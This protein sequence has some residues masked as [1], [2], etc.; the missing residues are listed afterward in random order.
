M[1]GSSIA[2]PASRAP[3]SNAVGAQDRPVLWITWER[4]R[5][6]L[7]LAR[8]LNADLLV[9]RGPRA[10]PARYLY[11]CYRTV[12]ELRRRRPRIVVGQNP[13]LILAATLCLLRP[14]LRFS[15]VIDRHSNF[16]LDKSGGLKWRMFHLLSRYTVR[17]A[18]L[19]IVTNEPLRRVVE[20]W[21]GRGFVLPDR[22]PTIEAPG[23]SRART[24]TIELVFICS[25]A[26]DEPLD[27]LRRAAA[28]LA[29]TWTLFVTG[30][31]RRYLR[32]NAEKRWPPNVRFTG[33]LDERDYWSLL[34]SCDA[35]IVLTTQ[36]HT[37]TCGAYEAVALGKPA[38]LSDTAT[39]R[40]YF[41]S[42]AVYASPNEASIAAGIS[43]AIRRRGEL[44]REMQVLRE[45]LSAS[46][47]TT[48]QDLRRHLDALVS[49]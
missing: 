3:A 2:A 31:G 7:E 13:S 28:T 44:A 41:A 15:L 10:R 25:F 40:E 32:G 16:E 47:Q 22:L 43:E 1:R 12:R 34:Q 30:D 20:S 14:L 19:T 23:P 8:A 33:F 27:E 18:D 35:I 45:R 42:G 5:R 9:L 26:G 36:E 11:L 38:V 37:L 21:G 6:S 49:A 39:I 48:F 4:Q 17:R 24:G 46:W 29:P